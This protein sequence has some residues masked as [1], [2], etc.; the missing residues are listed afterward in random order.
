M[1]SRPQGRR[2][3]WRW[4]RVS[5]RIVPFDSFLFLLRGDNIHKSRRLGREKL[6]G[7]GGSLGRIGPLL[8]RLIAFIN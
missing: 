6:T 5:H 7:F 3:G 8:L 2:R 1:V 4:I